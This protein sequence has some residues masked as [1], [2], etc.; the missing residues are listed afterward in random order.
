MSRT[1]GKDRFYRTLNLDEK[2]KNALRFY[3]ELK[4]AVEKSNKK[5]D[6]WQRVRTKEERWVI[7]VEEM[8]IA[9]VYQPGSLVECLYLLGL[10]GF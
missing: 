9:I 10:Y 3:T 5:E 6:K 7:G 4:K 8:K 1:N 2:E